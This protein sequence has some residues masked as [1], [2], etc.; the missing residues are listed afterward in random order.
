[1]Q[2]FVL[3]WNPSRT[4]FMEGMPDV[5]TFIGW[6]T[7]NLQ[8]MCHFINSHLSVLQDH[9]IDTFHVCIINGCGLASS[10]FPML[11]AFAS[12]FEH[13]D[14]FTENPLWYD[15]VPILHWHHSMQFGTWYTFSPQKLITA[16]CSSLVQMKLEYPR[17]W[18]KTHDGNGLSKSHLH[19]NGRRGVDHVY[20]VMPNQQWSQLQN[21]Y[22]YCG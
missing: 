14:P 10:S 11:N 20:F 13:L 4:D 15:T 3:L 5:D 12:I 1:V 19:Y 9:A 21:M 18:H 17:L 8:L 22:L 6:I 7:T 16:L 2:F